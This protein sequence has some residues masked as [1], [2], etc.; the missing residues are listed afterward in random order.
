MNKKLQNQDPNESPLQKF[1]RLERELN[2]LK[3]ELTQ[4]DKVA[5]ENEK[6]NSLNFNP[7]ELTKEVE[8]LQK[9]IK[10][11]HLQSIGAKINISDL[12]NKAKKYIF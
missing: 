2:E 5:S 7:V 10:S 12:D 8:N 11:L 1:K 6:L 9:Q 3:V 4:A